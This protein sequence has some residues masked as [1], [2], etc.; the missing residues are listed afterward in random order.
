MGVG[1]RK[2]GGGGGGGVRGDSPSRCLG[3]PRQLHRPDPH[4]R[5]NLSAGCFSLQSQGQ[6]EDI[7]N[8]GTN[9]KKITPSPTPSPL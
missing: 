5:P 2:E 8:T 1:E 9:N 3:G 6:T 4:R 7:N